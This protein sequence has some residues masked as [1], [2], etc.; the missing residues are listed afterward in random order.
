MSKQD[1]ENRSAVLET[2]AGY[3]SGAPNTKENLAPDLIAI[4]ETVT[5]LYEHLPVIAGDTSDIRLHPVYKT[6]GLVFDLICKLGYEPQL[7]ERTTKRF[8]EKHNL[9]F[10]KE[11]LNVTK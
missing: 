4:Y 11:N 6:A 1:S 2:S 3:L 8:Y 5:D 9:F 10:E 7:Q